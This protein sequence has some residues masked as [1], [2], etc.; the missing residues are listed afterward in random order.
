MN[1]QRTLIRE[2]SR[3][4]FAALLFAA[5][6]LGGCASFGLAGDGDGDVDGEGPGGLT[7]ETRSTADPGSGQGAGN[8]GASVATDGERSVVAAEVPVPVAPPERVPSFSAARPGA[9]RLAGWEPWVIHPAKQLTRYRLVSDGDRTV[10]RARAS[11]SASGLLA[12]V[13][14]DPTRTPVMRWSWKALTLPLDADTSVASREDSPLRVVIAFD[15][16]KNSLPVGDRLFFERVKLFTGRD[17]PYATLMYVWEH[18]KPLETVV[19]NPHTGR[20]RKIVVS[21]GPEG[22]RN[23]QRFQRNL[24]EDYQRAFGHRPGRV[25]GVAVMTDSDNLRQDVDAIYGD[26]SL[27]SH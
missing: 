10:L 2:P 24:V 9:K 14:A 27:T 18:D 5:T 21:S 15:G 4:W 25:V 23:W 17:M 3:I 11:S 12:R 8:S 19:R 20:V 26:I 6:I 1:T 7:A 16:D 22:V 13:D